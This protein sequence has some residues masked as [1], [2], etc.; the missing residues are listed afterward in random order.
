MADMAMP[1]RLT[2]QGTAIDPGELDAAFLAARAQIDATGYGRFV[3]D[4]MC[5]EISANVGV[6][7][8]NYRNGK[9]V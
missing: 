5:H 3:S 9:T 8:E 2:V 6:A 7:I 1:P 4:E